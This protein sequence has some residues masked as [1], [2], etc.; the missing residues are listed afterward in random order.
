MAE[1]WRMTGSARQT[2]DVLL[3]WMNQLKCK[4]FI[5][6]G[7]GFGERK[8]QKSHRIGEWRIYELS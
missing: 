2:L 6:Q 4:V 7:E 3:T 5:E 1:G 8:C